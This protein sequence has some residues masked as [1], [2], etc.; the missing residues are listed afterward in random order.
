[1]RLKPLAKRSAE[2][3]NRVAGRCALAESFHCFFKDTGHQ[4]LCG[5]E[6]WLERWQYSTLGFP[7][8][9]RDTAQIIRAWLSMPY[10]KPDPVTIALGK[11]W[12]L[13]DSSLLGPLALWLTRLS[14]YSTILKALLVWWCGPWFSFL[15]TGQLLWDMLRWS[16]DPETSRLKRWSVAR[17]IFGWCCLGHFSSFGH[18]ILVPSSSFIFRT[19]WAKLNGIYNHSSQQTINVSIWHNVAAADLGGHTPPGHLGCLACKA[20]HL[21]EIHW[22]CQIQYLQYMQ[23]YAKIIKY[24]PYVMIFFD[25]SSYFSWFLVFS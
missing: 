12:T 20:G 3:E 4:D 17:L 16:W 6:G 25:I 9:Q 1:M 8:A 13:A 11:F 2:I 10:S 22:T 14:L 21:M 18:T 15:Y 5:K 19:A 24:G 23:I 7:H